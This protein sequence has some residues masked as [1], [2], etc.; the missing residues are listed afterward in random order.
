[1]KHIDNL[2]ENPGI[3]AVMTATDPLTPQAFMGVKSWQPMLAG[4]MA[5]LAHTNEDGLI[6]RVGEHSLFV[7]RGAGQVVA[8]VI[9]TGH[10]VAKSIQRL[11]RL[12]SRPLG[13]ESDRAAAVDAVLN[14][15][16]KPMAEDAQT[17]D[18]AAAFGA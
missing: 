7:R 6:F 11:L 18:I 12:A 1:M 17:L 2:I 9:P 5:L 15:D 14:R 3:V 8:A 16:H 4:T 10:Q 13:R